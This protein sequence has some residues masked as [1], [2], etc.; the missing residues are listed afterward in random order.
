MIIQQKL[1]SPSAKQS[2]RQLNIKMEC[3]NFALPN[4]IKLVK[5]EPGIFMMH[6]HTEADPNKKWNYV[7]RSGKPCPSGTDGTCK[8]KRRNNDE[9]P[10][11]PTSP[12]NLETNKDGDSPTIINVTNDR[13]VV[14]ETPIPTNEEPDP[15][16]LEPRSVVTNRETT[17]PMVLISPPPVER[18]SR[19]QTMAPIGEKATNLGDL[20]CTL[21]FNVK[22]NT[23]DA[24]PLAQSVITGQPNTEPCTTHSLFLDQSDR[25]VASEKS[26]KVTELTSP[27]PSEL[28]PEKV[29][30]REITSGNQVT[31]NLMKSPT[32]TPGDHGD[33][34]LP[35]L[36]LNQ[37]PQQSVVTARIKE[38]STKT[39][40][41]EPHNPKKTV[42]QGT[43]ARSNS[44]NS[45]QP[46]TTPRSV[47][48]DPDDD[49]LQSANT[50]LQLGSQDELNLV[51]QE[52]DNEK[53]LPVGKAPEEDFTK[54]MS[55]LDSNNNENSE[56]SDRTVDY[57]TLTQNEQTNRI[58][59]DNTSP[60]GVVKY[61]HYRIRRHSPAVSQPRR[62]R[63]ITCGKICDSKK[64][65][66]DHF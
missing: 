50:L 5:P 41:E 54:Q 38:E 6:R 3:P 64:R 61:K 2:A 29:P 27:D 21:N 16:L 45:S 36:V 25:S 30:D 18:K 44:E 63:C 66:N 32:V 15:G 24:I 59:E 48:T 28:S 62:L 46:S 52:I 19:V 31:A 65:L 49:E 17:P 42:L 10:D 4:A 58:N 40:I 35:N 56:D 43:P 11:L 8:H 1:H 7:H 9:L 34:F 57:S 37:T 39:T 26:P 51:D 33:E 23:I 20:L 60:K 22:P 12:V 55:A 13:S 53:I 47:L 14:T